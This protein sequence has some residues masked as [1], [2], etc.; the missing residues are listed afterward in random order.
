MT[1][2]QVRED[3]G[4]RRILPSCFLEGLGTF[5]FGLGLKVLIAN[6]IGNLWTEVG[7]IGYESISTPL[8]WMGIFAFTFQIYFDFFG[9]S[10]MAIGLGKMLGFT[11]PKNFDHPYLSRS[12][13][14]FWRRWHITLGSWFREYIYIPLGGNRAGKLATVRNLMVVWLLTGLWHG[15]GYNF[16]LWGALLFVILFLEK[17][18]YGKILDRVPVIGHLYMLLLIPL[19]W[20]LFA[21]E[22]ADRLALF[23]TRLFPFFGQGPWS[24]FRGDWLKYSEQYWY[25]FVIGIFFS[26]TLPYRIL[27]KIKKCRWLLIPFLAAVLGVSLYCLWR[28]FNDPFLYFRF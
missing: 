5:I 16:V 7:N 18:V 8:A 28:G 27:E 14:E 6:P 15:D 2:D 21:I 1:Y 10:V 23:F 11:I 4:E 12:M 13:T 17:Y 24:Q 20:S 26:T 3:L 19:S 25:L 9:Y 22:R